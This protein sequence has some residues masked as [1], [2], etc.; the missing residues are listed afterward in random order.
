MRRTQGGFSLFVEGGTFCDSEIVVLLGQNGTG[1]STLIRLLAGAIRPDDESSEAELPQ[2]SVSYKPQKI[3]SDAE[4]TVRL[5]FHKRIRAVYS[6]PA[7]VADVVKP[8]GIDRLMDRDLNT[9]SGGELQRVSLAVCVGTKANLY[10]IDEPSAYLDSE[11]RMI[12]AKVIKKS[13]FM[14]VIYGEFKLGVIKT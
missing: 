1:K 7:F 3:K 2:L 12:A 11:Q 9:L 13:I 14:N 5:L 6:T 10:L 4:G 8:L